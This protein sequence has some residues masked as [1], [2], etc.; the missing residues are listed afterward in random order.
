MDLYTLKLFAI[1]ACLTALVTQKAME[2]IIDMRENSF[3]LKTYISQTFAV[4]N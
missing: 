1:N 3:P 4:D 2:A